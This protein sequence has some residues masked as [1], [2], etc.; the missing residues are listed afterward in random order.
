SEGPPPQVG[1]GIALPELGIS[2][3]GAAI[4]D[5]RTGEYTPL[6]LAR[7]DPKITA[8]MPNPA[9]FVGANGQI[10]IRLVSSDSAPISTDMF[11]LVVTG[12][13]R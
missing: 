5:Q 8:A 12:R 2:L 10:D 6:T 13:K 1:G 11:E 4:R 3:T 7:Q 9:R